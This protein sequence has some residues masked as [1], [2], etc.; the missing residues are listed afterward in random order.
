MRQ[1][2][3]DQLFSVIRAKLTGRALPLSGL[4]DTQLLEWPCGVRENARAVAGGKR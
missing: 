2:T 4:N 1:T 3:V